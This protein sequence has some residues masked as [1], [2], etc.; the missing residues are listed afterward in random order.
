MKERIIKIRSL[1]YQD[2]SDSIDPTMYEDIR[3]LTK[4]DTDENVIIWVKVKDVKEYLKKVS[5]H[6]KETKSYMQLRYGYD[7]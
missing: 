6:L 2:Y 3:C 1:D 4:P 7:W 5:Y